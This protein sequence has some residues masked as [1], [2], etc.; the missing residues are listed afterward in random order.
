MPLS[1]LG[2]AV[3][4]RG[5]PDSDVWP[6]AIV[7]TAAILFAL[8]GRG[9]WSGALVGL[10][11]GGVFWG[12]HISWLTLYLGLVP[13]AALAVLQAIFFSLSAGLMAVASTRGYRV[14]TGPLGRM[15]GLPAVLAALWIGRETVTNV[16]PYGGFA[17][18]RLALSQ[19]ISPLAGLAAWVASPGSASS[20]RSSR[21]CSPKRFARSRCRPRR[22][23]PRSWLRRRGARLP[24][25]AG[26]DGGDDADRGGAG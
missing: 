16:W 2:G 26:S 13:W 18:G 23:R 1:A 17:W 19:S 9:F 8:A 11:G 6:L 24:G 5:F 25:L 10:V 22:A 14:W 21:L 4:D 15:V 3:L 20:S 7:G 12:V